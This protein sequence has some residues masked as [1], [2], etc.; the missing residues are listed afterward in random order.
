MKLVV[1]IIVVATTGCM[2]H[3]NLS[4]PPATASSAERL[5][6]YDR[7]SPRGLTAMPG[8]HNSDPDSGYMVLG[9]GSVISHPD[10]VLPVIAP[11]S[12]P[13]RA[14]RAYR[15]SWRS[16]K[17]WL[18]AGASTLVVAIAT[19]AIGID[20]MDDPAPER[21]MKFA[22]ATALPGAALGLTFFG[23]GTYYA[24]DA[25]RERI[26]AFHTYDD[27]LRRRL[28]LCVDGLRVVDCAGANP[29]ATASTS[30]APP[31]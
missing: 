13:A 22:L 5:A 26:S 18:I 25:Y 4:A 3:V 2:P 1:G 11:D 15:S 31:R 28:G 6:A 21:S 10:D 24:V 14:G 9:D 19:T 7:L 8:R 23:I 27:A 29:P 16:T 30:L 12:P 17:G 20:M